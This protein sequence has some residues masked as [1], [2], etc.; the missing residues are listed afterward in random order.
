MSNLPTPDEIIKDGLAYPFVITLADGREVT[1]RLSEKR[2]RWTDGYNLYDIRHSDNDWCDPATIENHQVMV[3]WFGTFIAD[4][5]IVFA[6]GEDY[7]DIFDYLYD[8]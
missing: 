1:G 7:I 5:P 6:D 4:E 2:L 3:N 8:D